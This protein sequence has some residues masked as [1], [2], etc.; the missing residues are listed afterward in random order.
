MY[1]EI[2]L[3][4]NVEVINAGVPAIWSADE[5]RKIKGFVPAFEPDLF[6]VYDGGAEVRDHLHRGDPTATATHWK[7]RWIEICELGKKY[8]YETIITLL[9]ESMKMNI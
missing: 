8:D 4:F 6:I 3:G 1:D 9:D 2:D 5:V 7:E